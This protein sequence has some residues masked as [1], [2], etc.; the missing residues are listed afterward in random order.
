MSA[1]ADRPLTPSSQISIDTASE[2]SVVLPCLN[3]AQTIHPTIARALRGIA[4][5][6]LSG[7]VIVVD[8]GSSDGSD[9]IAA[10]AGA[11]VVHESRPGYGSALLRGFTE[12]R[13]RFVVMAD[14]DDT[15]Q[16]EDL[17]ALIACLHEGNDLAVANRLAG[18][19]PDAMPW[20]H[21]YVGTPA[22]S[23][24]LRRVY[25][26]CVADSQSGFRAMTRAALDRLDL[27][28]PGMELASEMLIKAALGD[29]R[30]AEVPS[31]YQSRVGDS[32]LRTF[33][34]GCRHLRLILLLAPTY[35]YILPGI[36]L[37]ILGILTFV[38][39]FAAAGGLDVGGLRWQPVF[40]GPIFLVVGVNAVSMGLVVGRLHTL[41]GFSRRRAAFR[42]LERMMRA[43]VGLLIA[44]IAVLAGIGMDVY[45]FAHW[46]GGGPPHPI[47]TQLAALAQTLVI[48]GTNIG[49]IGF[50][51][52]SHEY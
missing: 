40:A 46:A 49:L 5:S 44:A 35:L 2:I 30:V 41:R 27:R 45:L 47:G 20:L 34:D 10:I 15:Y 31:S 21:R 32:K 43:E 24:L 9:R 7:E 12:A 48:V 36:L 8:N 37:T 6:G 39:A 18:V 14:A 4:G 28:S 42:P 16:L 17:P 52:T 22:I 13:G 1:R 33:R 11:R 29:L 50:L 3:E 51:A 38:L 25:G 26:V 23:W 19:S